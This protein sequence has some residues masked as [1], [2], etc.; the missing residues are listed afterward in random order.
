[1]LKTVV[2]IVI[3][4]VLGGAGH[5]LLSKGMKS[6]GDLTES[7]ADRLAPMVWNAITNP[8]VLFGVALQACFFF[9]YLALLSRAAITQVL[10]MTAID[11]IVVALLAQAVL[12]E[13]V[14]PVRWAGIGCIVLGVCLVSQS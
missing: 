3:A 14:T 1:M 10:P 11:Y 9:M 7:A 5:V 8:W 2:L 13:T 12:A 4:S 6:I